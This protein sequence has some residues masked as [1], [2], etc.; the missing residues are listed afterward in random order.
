MDARTSKMQKRIS[1]KQ[2]RRMAKDLGGRVQPA[3]GAMKNAKGDVR[4]LG[5]VRG[6]AKY[7]SKES[8]ILKKSELEKI[9]NEAGLERAVLQ[10]CFIGRATNRPVATFAIFP[11]EPAIIG[12]PDETQW[13]EW[14]TYGKSGTILRDR[15]AVKLLQNQG[16]IW[17]VFST[18]TKHDWY[19]LME[20]SD[21]L[22]KMEEA[23]A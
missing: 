20:W 8:F 1:N 18:K 21:Y 13:A 4:K 10:L 22:S 3:S 2:E 5:V 9:V 19:Q 12:K 11:C 6:E 17:F 23:D 16:P 15:I 14:Q 7:T